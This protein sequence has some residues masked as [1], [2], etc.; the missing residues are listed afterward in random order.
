LRA[1]GGGS[2]LET[3]AIIAKAH[4]NGLEE[5]NQR[6]LKGFMGSEHLAFKRFGMNAVYY[7]LMVHTHF[8][9]EAFRKDVAQDILSQ[10]CYSTKLR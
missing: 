3:P 2:L 4:S 9:T 5:I 8:I 7:L 10:R 1:A 6:S